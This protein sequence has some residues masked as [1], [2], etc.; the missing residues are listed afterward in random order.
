MPRIKPYEQQITSQGDFP[1]RGAN[2]SDFGGPGLVN[3]GTGVQNLAADGFQIQRF[4]LANKSRQEVTDAETGLLRLAADTEQEL[5]T[6]YKQWKPGDPSL[7]ESYQGIIKQRLDNFGYNEDGTEKYETQA[8]NH[9]FRTGAERLSAQALKHA[10]HLDSDLAGKAAVMQYNETVAKQGNF[11]QAHP[12]FYELRKEEFGSIIDNPYGV[13]S[14]I[15]GVEREKLRQEGTAALA[16]AAAQ[17]HIRKAPH[18]M[19]EKFKD[20]ALAQDEQYGWMARDIPANK[21][22]DLIKT[23]HT[24]AAA[25]EAEQARLEAQRRRDAV[26]LSH[27]KHTELVSK[28]VAHEADHSQPMI[29]AGDILTAMEQGMDGNLGKAMLISLKAWNKEAQEPSHHPEVMRSTVAR[30]HLPPG[31]PNRIND[32]LPIYKLHEQ[33]KISFLELGQLNK[34]FSEARTPDGQRLGETKNK[35]IHAMTPQMDHSNPLMG[36]LDRTGPANVYQ[37]EQMVNRKIEEFRK[38]GK[39]VYQLFDPNSNEY[40]GKPERIA[41]FQKHMM[42]SIRDFSESMRTA[43]T[44]TDPSTGGT[45]SAKQRKPGETPAQYKERMSRG[46]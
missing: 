43:P 2:P 12:N 11:L 41:P 39:D 35:L 45:P 7:A 31:D 30:I 40:L 44:Q 25:L 16:I 33:G 8:G 36:K 5:M 23:A 21:F 13:Y 9:A 1:T 14:T 6:R 37:Y 34:E 20:P 24:E 10:S 27:E 19:L 32:N 22:D 28:W 38:E 18:V 15:P 4:L 17:G 42:E 46:N 26:D 29:G 3:A